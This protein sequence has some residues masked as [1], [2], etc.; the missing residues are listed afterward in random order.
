MQDGPKRP[1]LAPQRTPSASPLLRQQSSGSQ[2]GAPRSLPSPTAPLSAPREVLP[3]TRNLPLRSPPT[4]DDSPSPLLRRRAA[5]GPSPGLSRQT[6]PRATRR[7]SFGDETDEQLSRLVQNA[8]PTFSTPGAERSPLEA[9][10]SPSVIQQLLGRLKHEERELLEQRIHSGA[11]LLHGRS[12]STGG[13]RAAALVDG[14]SGQVFGRPVSNGRAGSR[15]GS[16]SRAR[17]APRAAAPLVTSA[18]VQRPLGRHPGKRRLRRW[19]NAHLVEMQKVLLRDKARQRSDASSASATPVTDGE[20]AEDDLDDEEEEEIPAFQVEYKSQF[21]ELMRPEHK[22]AQEF[23][24]KGYVL[25]ERRGRVHRPQR[26]AVPR[27]FGAEGGWKA[28]K[29]AWR[30]VEKRLRN[31]TMKAVVG[32][33]RREGAFAAVVEALE[34]AIRDFVRTGRAPAPTGL[35]DV[36]ASPLETESP[37]QRELEVGWLRV[38]LEDNPIHRLLLHALA[39]F[40]GLKSESANLPGLGRVTYVRRPSKLRHSSG[41][42]MRLVDFLAVQYAAAAAAAATSSAA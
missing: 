35:K 33:S 26:T 23:F 30:R 42:P 37:E 31:V 34:D 21:E 11:G 19:E 8:V 20:D 17:S 25:P 27:V 9:S 10:P 6:P 16:R 28:E 38:H 13:G 24:I 32:D 7:V 5:D 41:L 29:S 39:A 4:D 12:H 3:L 14:V 40:H 36:I 1:P 2:G 22:D 15:S 18:M